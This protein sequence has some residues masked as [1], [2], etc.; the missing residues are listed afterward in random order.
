MPVGPYSLD[1]STRGDATRRKRDGVLV[2]ALPGG[3]LG[4]AWQRRNGAVVL[5]AESLSGIDTLRFQL[6]LDDDHSPFLRLFSRD[7][8]LKHAIGRLP[9]L[10]PMRLGTV[11][12]ALL[13]A[14][15]GQLIEAR[16]ARAIEWRI[17]RAA[18]KEIDGLQAPPT[19]IDLARFA[20]VELRRSCESAA[21]SRSSG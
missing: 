17:I 8:L 1:L 10:R 21:S 19:T 14:F 6:A 9:W 16:R 20:P 11:A 3:G 15:C 4:A 7:P 12:H 2:V 18:T 5:R 13:R